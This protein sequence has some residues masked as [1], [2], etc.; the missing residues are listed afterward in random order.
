M[1]HT[2]AI[3]TVLLLGSVLL[4]A[5]TSGQ[6]HSQ[7]GMEKVVTSTAPD[8]STIWTTVPMTEAERQKVQAMSASLPNTCPV[9]LTAQ[10]SSAAFKR[11]V[12]SGSARPDGI[13]QW[14]H[15]NIAGSGSRRVVTATVTVHGFADKSRMLPASS[16]VLSSPMS[17]S[18]ASS[19]ASWT[20]NVRF[21]PAG[22]SD[23]AAQLR[24]PGMTGVTA[25]D[26]KAVTYADGSTWKLAQGSSCRV[27]I[28]GLMLVGNR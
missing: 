5:Q 13:A 11:E 8:G 4:T 19:D 22:A 7:A 20:E 28:G 16:A 24:V 27:S 14:L 17:S 2:I 25:I 12:G 9:S 18:A 1:N 10:Q 3:S 23:V 6:G 21:S 26:L 15:L